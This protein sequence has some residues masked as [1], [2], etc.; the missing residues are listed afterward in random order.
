MDNALRHIIQAV[1]AQGAGDKGGRGGSKQP[2]RTLGRVF[3][4]AS[5]AVMKVKIKRYVLC[6]A[7]HYLVL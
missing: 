7:R 6:E 2:G 5:S 3:F 4:F 1:G